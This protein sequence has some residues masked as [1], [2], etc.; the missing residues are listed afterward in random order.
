MFP[1]KGGKSQWVCSISPHPQKKI[2]KSL[3]NPKDLFPFMLKHLGLGIWF[4][5]GFFFEDRAKLETPLEIFPPLAFD[6]N[7]NP[8]TS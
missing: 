4:G 1:C 3:T 7:K 5:L 6:R 2:K 8:N